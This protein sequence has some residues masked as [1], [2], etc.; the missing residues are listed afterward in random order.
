MNLIFR[1]SLFFLALLSGLAAERSLDTALA[2]IIDG[3]FELDGNATKNPSIAGDDW[4]VLFPIDTG[5]TAIAKVFITDTTTSTCGYA[6][7]FG[8]GSK[9][10]L[11]ITSSR[12]TCGT[13][14]DKA[15]ITHAYAALY[16]H[17]TNLFL[18]F[19]ADRFDN[20]GTAAIGF[21]FMQ[22]PLG[23]ITSGPDAGKFSGSHTTSDLLVVSEFTQGGAVSTINVYRWVGGKNSLLLISS[24]ADCA[25]G[26]NDSVC[27]SVNSAPTASPW[28]YAPKTGSPNIFPAGCFFEGAINI[29]KLVPGAEC[30]ASFLAETRSSAKTDAALQ[31]FA[32]GRLGTCCLE[33]TK[34]A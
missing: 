34:T 22:N 26:T 27:A 11:D 25:T 10:G 29:S 17:T 20:G 19:G 15:E 2:G 31:D 28:P 6:T 33:V 5:S 3:T 18:V 13:S 8:S 16:H 9:D 23:L 24:C 7:V 4:S 12:F 32:L 14:P 30:F 1:K 21:W